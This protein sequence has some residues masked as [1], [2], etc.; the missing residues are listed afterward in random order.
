MSFFK[1]LL[2]VT[3]VF[4]M[5]LNAQNFEENRSAA[6]SPDILDKSQI[7]L[8]L[9]D[10]VLKAI[11]DEYNYISFI[12]E[13]DGSLSDSN[14]ISACDSDDVEECLED[15]TLENPY[16]EAYPATVPVRL[17]R[18]G[19]DYRSLVFFGTVNTSEWNEIPP[20]VN[21]E[22]KSVLSGDQFWAPFKYIKTFTGLSP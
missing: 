3:F 7:Q 2:L 19:R 6:V 15:K 17:L 18:D 16:S 10:D 5:L 11:N 22:V 4:P 12:T 8:N 1:S 21:S 14:S 20:A 9:T 13:E